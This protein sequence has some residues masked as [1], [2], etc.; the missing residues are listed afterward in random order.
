MSVVGIRLYHLLTRILVTQITSLSLNRPRPTI[1]ELFE[2]SSHHIYHYQTL[3]MSLHSGIKPC[4]S[5]HSSSA[6]LQY[7]S[8]IIKKPYNLSMKSKKYQSHLEFTPT[9]S[10]TLLGTHHLQPKIPIFTCLSK[11]NNVWQLETQSFQS[12]VLVWKIISNI[13]SCLEY[14]FKI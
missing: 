12:S 9:K 13:S 7:K 6:L 1:R 10:L 8:Y 3:I 5:S 2:H 11:P 4:L 14:H